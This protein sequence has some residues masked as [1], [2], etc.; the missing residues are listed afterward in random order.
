V[1]A[2]GREEDHRAILPD[3]VH[4]D[5]VD[6]NVM[7]SEKARKRSRKRGFEPG[8]L[9]TMPKMGLDF[10]VIAVARGKRGRTGTLTARA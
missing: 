7:V 5:V 10:A 2:G 1:H 6:P 3:S 8:P 9:L 4:D